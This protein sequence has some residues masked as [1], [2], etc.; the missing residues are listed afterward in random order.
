MPEQITVGELTA[1]FLE[2]C[3]VDTAFGVISIH[4][5]PILDAF[6]RRNTIRFVPSRGEAGAVNMADAFARVRG[7]LGVAITS[8]GTAAGNAAGAMVEA[9]TAGTP[10]LHLTGQIERA[11]LDKHW[12]YIHEANDQPTMLKAISKAFF[13]VWSPET[14]LGVLQEAVRTA[15]TAPTG[16]VSVEIPIDVQEALID[17]PAHIAPVPLSIA[18]ADPAAL[19]AMAEM[20]ARA[21]RPL[22][23]AGGGARHAAE[24]IKALADLGFTVV[25]S[26]QGRGVLPEDDTRTLGAFN[27]SP[28][29]ES[30]YAGCDAL[31]VVGSRLR[32][33]ETLKYTLKLPKPML[34]IDADPMAHGRGYTADLFLTADAKPALAGLAARLKGKLKVADSFAQDASAA[35]DE[36]EAQL[37]KGLGPYEK[38]V[39]ALQ[40]AVPRDY[41]WVRDVTVSNSTWGNR[42]LKLFDPRNGVHAL[43]GGIGMGAAMGVGAAIGSRGRKTVVLSGDGGLMLCVGELAT[44]AQEQAD[45]LLIVMN[46]RGYGVIRNIQDAKFGGRK[47][48][49]DLHTPSFPDLARSLGWRHILL[50]D[51]AKAESTI[52]QAMAESGPRMLEVD[53]VAIGPYASAFAGPPVRKAS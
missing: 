11:Y 32:G 50:N 45:M 26:V 52:D 8:T 33:N 34:Q 4:N 24:E 28:P 21:K 3:G 35:R 38:L 12:S 10:V 13:R 44:A 49:V 2:A 18:Q 30:F 47:Y 46:D 37:R 29:V 31:L 16:P 53:M 17:I 9:Q 25:T 15:L 39:D 22:L 23:W 42:M 14:A 5:M 1:R 36:A 19:D 20:L 51:I 41:L 48:F 7:H 40:K 27:L 43:G 6:G